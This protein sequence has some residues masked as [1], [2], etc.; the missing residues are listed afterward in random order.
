[1]EGQKIEQKRI[2]VGQKKERLNDGK[3]KEK[4]VCDGNEDREVE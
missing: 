1:M 3:K 4:T 2:V